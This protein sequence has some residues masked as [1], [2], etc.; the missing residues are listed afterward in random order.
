MSKPNFGKRVANLLRS[1]A[2]KQL[3]AKE[4]AE[5]LIEA[6][7]N[8]AA[9]KKHNSLN[10]ELFQDDSAF[11]NQVAAEI[12][13]WRP[14]LEDVHNIKV[15]ADRP[16]K[17]YFA[18]VSDEQVLEEIEASEQTKRGAATDFEPRQELS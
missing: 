2:P 11:L 1:S 15:T 5:S 18:Q 8:W 17:F 16:K 14:N 10:S 3:T 4:I 9:K 12:H 13:S 6:D 7:P